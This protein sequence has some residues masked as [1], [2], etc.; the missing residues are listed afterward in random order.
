MLEL[1]SSLR[2]PAILITARREGRRERGREGRR[3]KGGGKRMGGEGEKRERK[4][5]REDREGC[6]AGIFLYRQM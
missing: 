5:M 1:R 4:Y 3:E 2:L 6:E